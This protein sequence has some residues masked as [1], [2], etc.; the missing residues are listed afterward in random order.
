[1]YDRIHI[2]NWWSGLFYFSTLSIMG[3]RIFSLVHLQ[4]N[5]HLMINW[6]IC[7]V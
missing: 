6:L 3:L 7:I 1:M 4:K 5:V 2:C